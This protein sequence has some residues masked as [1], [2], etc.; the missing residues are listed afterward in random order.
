MEIIIIIIIVKQTA[1]QLHVPSDTTP[2]ASPWDSQTA[3]ISSS[4]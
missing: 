3:I 4:L 1:K 2:V